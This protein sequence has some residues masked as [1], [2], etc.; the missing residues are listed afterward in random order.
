MRMLEHT[1]EEELSCEDVFW[2]MAQYAEA[3]EEGKQP[4]ELMPMVKQHLDMCQECQDELEAVLAVL[5][6]TRS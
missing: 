4:E 2:L 6:A 3:L 5:E 1:Q